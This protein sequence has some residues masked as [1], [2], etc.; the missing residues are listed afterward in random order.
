MQD[1]KLYVGN[2][3]YSTSSERLQSAFSAHGTVVKVNVMEGKGFGFVEMAI[4]VGLVFVAL[5]YLW[6]MGALD[7]TGFRPPDRE[8][9][10]GTGR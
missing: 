6:R 4:F 7:W 9:K 1:S 5:A 3:N 10:I 2:L 8:G